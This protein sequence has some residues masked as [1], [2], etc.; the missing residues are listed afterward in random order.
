[1]YLFICY[2]S[3]KAVLFS[4]SF[5]G[6]QNGSY[7]YYLGQA[8]ERCD[9]ITHERSSWSNRGYLNKDRFIGVELWYNMH[10]TRGILEVYIMTSF[11]TKLIFRKQGNQGPGWKE[12]KYLFQNDLFKDDQTVSSWKQTAWEVFYNRINVAA[13]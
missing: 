11:K 5:L 7:F 13:N 3:T 2:K 4:L 1:M 8:H 9:L 12:Y 6:S 10:N